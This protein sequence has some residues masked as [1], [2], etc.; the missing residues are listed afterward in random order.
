VFDPFS[1]SGT[2]GMAALKLG[3]RYIGFEIDADQ[4][5]ASNDRL[6]S[7]KETDAPLFRVNGENLAI[8]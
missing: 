1:G 2:T 4:A 8:A 6:H 7:I 5:A 3:C